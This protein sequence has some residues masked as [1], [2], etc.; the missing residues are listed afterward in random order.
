MFVICLYIEC[1]PAESL[2]EGKWSYQDINWVE[3][4]HPYLTNF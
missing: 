1:Q 3:E 4:S 2:T